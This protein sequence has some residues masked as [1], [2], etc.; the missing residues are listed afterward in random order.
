RSHCIAVRD[1][2]GHLVQHL[3]GRRDAGNAVVD[4]LRL[5]P[6]ARLGQAQRR[7]DQSQEQGSVDS[8]SPSCPGIPLSFHVAIPF[9]TSVPMGLTAILSLQYFGQSI[10]GLRDKILSASPRDYAALRKSRG[11]YPRAGHT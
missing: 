3:A 5:L 9:G 4:P 7:D 1:V 6:L 11:A 8:C 10:D 2:G